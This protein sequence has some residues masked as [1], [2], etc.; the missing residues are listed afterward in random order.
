M[1]DAQRPRG[2]E[3]E[4]PIGIHPRLVLSLVVAAFAAATAFA[5]DEHE[6]R[7]GAELVVMAGDLRR[8]TSSAEPERSREGIRARLAGALS[9]LP[10]LLREAGAPDAARIGEARAALERGQWAALERVLGQ[11]S[12][13]HPLD[14][15]H[16]LPAGAT[17]ERLRVGRGI[18][19]RACAGC[20]DAPSGDA[21]LPA[22]DLFRLAHSMP[23]EEFAARLINGVRGDASTGHRN[24]FG[25]LEIAA[26]V[27]YYANG[28][29]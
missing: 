4:D 14:L 20:H 11:L 24:P 12:A 6:R 8:L 5:Q 27:A 15:S 18:H 28:I 22:S 16:I 10:L 9:A 29:R 19:R 21:A 13:R 25:D 3:G 2:A 23:A 17:P 1:D 26:L 7:L